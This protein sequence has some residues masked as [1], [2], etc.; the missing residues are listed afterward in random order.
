MPNVGP[1]EIIVV[2]AL[3]L[4]IFGPKR[5]PELGQSLGKGLREFKSS[6]TG[7]NDDPPAPPKPI[8]ATTDSTAT[9]VDAEPVEAKP[10][11]SS[12]GSSS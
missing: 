9:P 12:T 8:T 2:L 4:I 5:L 1:L 10:D 6:V 3:V 7:D 11:D